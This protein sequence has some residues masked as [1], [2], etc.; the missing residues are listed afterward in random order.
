MSGNR[1]MRRNLHKPAALA[2][3]AADARCQIRSFAFACGP[4]DLGAS[5]APRCRGEDSLQRSSTS[6]GE[7]ALMFSF[8]QGFVLL[9]WTVQAPAF[10][11]GIDFNTRS[12]QGGPI[13]DD[14]VGQLAVKWV[15]QTVPDTGTANAAQG[16]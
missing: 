13:S 7:E 9:L 14:T 4:S 8:R 3:S 1:R 6:P 5:I 15:Y 12:F 2:H 11:Q 10:A 16:S